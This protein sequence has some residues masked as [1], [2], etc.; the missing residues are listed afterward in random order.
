MKIE[1]KKV[2]PKN[3]IQ[4]LDPIVLAYWI[5]CDGYKKNKGVG[6]A[7]N[8]F[9]ISDNQLLI[10]VLNIKFG[11]NSWIV[12]DHNLPTI[13]IPK[14]D[15]NILQNIVSPYMYPTLLYKIHL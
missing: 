1:K 8:S 14:S 10:N 6:L 13:F 12:D 15:L 5:M 4:I 9:S 11:F 2:I 3:I 7:T